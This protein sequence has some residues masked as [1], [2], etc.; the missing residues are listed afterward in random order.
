MCVRPRGGVFVADEVTSEGVSYR[1][2]RDRGSEHIQDLFSPGYFTVDL[3]DGQ[4][5]AL[6]ASV[7]PWDLL[8]FESDEIVMAEQ[9]RLEHLVSL[10]PAL[11]QD[12]LSKQL[13]LAADQFI[14]QPGARPEEQAIAQA[15]GDDARTVIA[16]YHW[17]GDWGRD[18][19]ISLEGLT[20]CTG[21]QQETRAILRDVRSLHPGRTHSQ[22]VSRRIAPSALPYSRRHALVFPCP[23]SLSLG[24]R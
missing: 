20:L 19:M 22:P 10:A 17:F 13:Q 2:D 12:D 3:S 14:V 9:R 23:R 21:R 5:V 18:T 4:R 1:V 8:D 24:D 11:Q 7:E 6:V 16:G 15:S